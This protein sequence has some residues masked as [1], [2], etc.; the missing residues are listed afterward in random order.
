MTRH[1]KFF[2]IV[3][4]STDK[5]PKVAFIRRAVSEAAQSPH[6]QVKLGGLT[7]MHKH[8]SRRLGA[9]VVVVGVV[10]VGQFLAPA[11]ASSARAVTGS[12]AVVAAAASS[13]GST[14][15]NA[16]TRVVRVPG[17]GFSQIPGTGMSAL[18]ELYGL[19]GI[20]LA[21][22]GGL[23]VVVHRRGVRA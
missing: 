11:H 8:V 9:G 17:S 15:S 3:S 4:S 16:G 10:G 21:G 6:T 2:T 14:V 19:L 12:D 1:E 7:S 18:T 5:G 23:S 20:G 13:A 22:V